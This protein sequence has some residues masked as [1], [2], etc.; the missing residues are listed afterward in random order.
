M[1]ASNP[2]LTEPRAYVVPQG[3]L[4]AFP[5]KEAQVAFAQSIAKWVSTKAAKHKYLRGGVI[6][7]DAIPK[8]WVDSVFFP[9][10]TFTILILVFQERSFAKTFENALSRSFRPVHCLSVHDS[11]W[12]L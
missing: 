4:A 10:H 1:T 12:Y 9:G 11:E 8:R 5:M 3:G 7:V 2:E 6:L